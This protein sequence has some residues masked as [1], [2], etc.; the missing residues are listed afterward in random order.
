MDKRALNQ[1]Q[2]EKSIRLNGFNILMETL[3]QILIH[4]QLKKQVD[5]ECVG[6]VI[7]FV[8]L[9]H[10]EQSGHA[11]LVAGFVKNA[12]KMEGIFVFPRKSK[13]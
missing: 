3:H 13:F 11:Y 2:N 8:V 1:R 12:N 4:V 6:P 10:P 7:D 5:I 9:I